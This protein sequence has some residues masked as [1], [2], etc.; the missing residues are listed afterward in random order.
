MLCCQERQKSIR[1]ISFTYEGVR[2]GGQRIRTVFG[3]P[4][5]N[6][7]ERRGVQGV[8]VRDLVALRA[9]I[10]C[11][12]PLDEHDIG[13]CSEYEGQQFPPVPGLADDLQSGLL[14]Q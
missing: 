3:T 12:C 14:L 10:D 11:Q 4:A 2:T 7:D 1:W 5:Q 8:Q 9:R 6:D 13:V